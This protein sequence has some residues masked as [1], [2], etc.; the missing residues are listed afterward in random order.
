MVENFIHLMFFNFSNHTQQL[1]TLHWLSEKTDLPNG[2]HNIQLCASATFE[3]RQSHRHW[4]R[5]CGCQ[6][7]LDRRRHKAYSKCDISR[8][9]R[10]DG[11]TTQFRFVPRSVFEVR[12]QERM[13]RRSDNLVQVCTTKCI[14]SATAGT[15]EMTVRQLSSGLYHEVYSKCDSR[16]G[17]EDGQT[18]QFRFV[19]RSVFEVRQ[20]ERMRRRSDNSVQVCTTKCIR[21]A[22]LAGTD[23]KTVRQLSSG[24]YHEV[25]SKCDSRNGWEDVQTTQFWFVPR[26]V[27]EVQ[28][29]E[30]MRRRSDNSVQVCT[31]KCIRSAT[32][33]GTDEK[34]VRQLSSGLY[35]F[36][37]QLC[38]KS[39]HSWCDGSSDR[40]F[41][42]VSLN[43]FSFQ[44]VIHNWCNNGCG[45]C[46]PVCGMMLIKEPFMGKE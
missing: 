29:Q 20:Q 46:Y 9:W 19:P 22:T 32:L 38:G 11:Q 45:M 26:S 21:S 8:N 4:L 18:T 33:A 17:W 37:M 35:R 7:L 40:S 15:D 5:S 24:L 25:Y 10:E 27:F 42:V 43:Y 30:R 31:T 13:R 34:T 44:P 12:Q 16:N 41:M 23:E 3:P 36:G 39:I 1:P 2:C 28:Q 14:R 6:N